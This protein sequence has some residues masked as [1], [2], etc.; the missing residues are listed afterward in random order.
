MDCQ[1]QEIV[2]FLNTDRMPTRME[3]RSAHASIPAPYGVY[4]TKDAWLTLA[5]VPL[6]ILGEVLDNDFLRTLT[7]YNDG[8]KHRDEIYK[9][10]RHSFQEKTTAEWIEICDRVGAWCGPVYNYEELVKDPHIVETK[11]IWEQPQLRG[12]SAKTVRPPVRL[13]DT[14]PTIRR[15]APALGEH[16]KEILIDLLGMPAT[17]VEELIKSGAVGTVKE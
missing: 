15:G 6:S 8:H 3:E 14:P 1:L 2:T 5:M 13:S 17:K 10:I 4:K 16:T 11:Y 12:G 9:L 7:H